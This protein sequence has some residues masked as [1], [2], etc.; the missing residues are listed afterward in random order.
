METWKQEKRGLDKMGDKGVMITSD[1][2]L[3][4]GNMDDGMRD[5]GI[6]IMGQGGREEGNCWSKDGWRN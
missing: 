5:R 1:R 4:Q 6:I 2:G 3:G